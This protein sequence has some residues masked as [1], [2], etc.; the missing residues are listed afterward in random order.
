MYPVI[1][2]CT[3][4][5]LNVRRTD[6]RTNYM[7]VMDGTN[8]SSTEEVWSNQQRFNVLNFRIE[9]MFPEVENLPDRPNYVFDSGFGIVAAQVQVNVTKVSRSG[10]LSLQ[11]NLNEKISKPGSSQHSFIGVSIQSAENIV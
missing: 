3:A 2:K 4:T 11:Y 8:T 10:Q 5:I 1:S 6:N 7:F 9:S